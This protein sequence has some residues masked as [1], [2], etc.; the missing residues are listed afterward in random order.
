MHLEEQQGWGQDMRVR[1]R[2]AQHGR[3]SADRVERDSKEDVFSKHTLD[4][5][6]PSD[7]LLNTH[8][9]MTLLGI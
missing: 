5:I 9:K 8:V 3:C 4:C 1:E 6:L 2:V 7:Y